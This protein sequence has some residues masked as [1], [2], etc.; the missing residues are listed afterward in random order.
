MTT[1]RHTVDALPGGPGTSVTCSES[2]TQFLC[3]FKPVPKV[4]GAASPQGNWRNQKSL[5]SHGPRTTLA[6]VVVEEPAP[7]LSLVCCHLF[8]IFG[9]SSAP[10]TT[11]LLKIPQEFNIHLGHSSSDHV[12]LAE[13]WQAASS[14]DSVKFHLPLIPSALSS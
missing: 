13:S 8:Q 7:I 6:G 1:T 5:K 10:G 4:T 9:S 3:A 11:H 14:R 2:L 12:S